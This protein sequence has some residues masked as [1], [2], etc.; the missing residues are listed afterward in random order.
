MDFIEFWR[1]WTFSKKVQIRAKLTQIVNS[2]GPPL[3]DQE[4]SKG[5]VWWDLLI[6]FSPIT[7]KTFSFFDLLESYLSHYSSFPFLFLSP[8]LQSLLVFIIPRLFV[9]LFVFPVKKRAISRSF[10]DA[11]SPRHSLSIHHGGVIKNW[12]FSANFNGTATRVQSRISSREQIRIFCSLEREEKATHLQKEFP[13]SLQSGRRRIPVANSRHSPFRACCSVPLR[14]G[15]VGGS[16]LLGRRLLPVKQRN[17]LRWNKKNSQFCW[18]RRTWP[19]Y[20]PLRLPICVP[21]RSDS[22]PGCRDL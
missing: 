6:S 2:G 20:I 1:F 11:T 18:H 5:L 14:P 10:P 3:S 12:H 21:C 9:S 7:S 17:I 16:P 4:W 15:D 22:S 8:S 13:G 19:G